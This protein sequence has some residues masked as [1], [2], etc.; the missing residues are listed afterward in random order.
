[1]NLPIPPHVHIVTHHRLSLLSCPHPT[2]LPLK[3]QLKSH[4]WPLLRLIALFVVCIYFL[5]CVCRYAYMYCA[6]KLFP[7]LKASGGSRLICL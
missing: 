4:L 6:T 7:A 5:S 1:M 3:L 2:E